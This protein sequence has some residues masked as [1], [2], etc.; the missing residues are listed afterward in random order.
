MTSIAEGYRTILCDVVFDVYSPGDI[1]ENIGAATGH[2][3]MLTP[4]KD[5]AGQVG[6][7][8]ILCRKKVSGPKGAV[9]SFIIT[10]EEIP[11]CFTIGPAR[12]A[13]GSLDE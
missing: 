7:I 13:F 2:N 3:W 1:V 11:P 4:P 10:D 5:L 12:R 8:L 6:A 9:L